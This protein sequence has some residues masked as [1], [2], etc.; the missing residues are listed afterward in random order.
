MYDHILVLDFEATCESPTP[1]NY[2]NEIIEFPVQMLKGDVIKNKKIEPRDVRYFQEYV[3]P[4]FKPILSDFCKRLTGITQKQVNNGRPLNLVLKD[5]KK[6]AY[7]EIN[8]RDMIIVV[9]FGDWDIDTCL[10][11]QLSVLG[12]RIPPILK[13]WIDLKE[14]FSRFTGYKGKTSLL[15]CLDY[16]NLGFEG[17]HHS[18]LDDTKNTTRLLMAMI[19]RGYNISKAKVRHFNFTK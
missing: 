11:R 7:E 16:Y 10:R 14:E 13:R 6:W 18:G 5:F 8:P 4:D 17:N 19:E 2:Y 1:Q 12:I 3:Y 9:T 15:A